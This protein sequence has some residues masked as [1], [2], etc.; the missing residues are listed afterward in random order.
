MTQTAITIRPAEIGDAR[1][2]ESVHD[3]AW[4][5]AY[6][7]IIPGVELERMVAR[8]GASWWRSAIRRGARIN[9]LDHQDRIAG[10]ASYGRNRSP[11][12]TQEA[13]IYELYLAPEFQGFGLGVRLFRAT[14]VNARSA[15]LKGVAVWA[16][17]GNE[18][19]LV[20]YTRLGGKVLKRSTGRFGKSIYESTAFGWD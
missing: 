8:R 13:E 5:E 15:G 19:A 9:V 1:G 6:R 10:Y 4:R 17:S 7:G 2:I 11:W 14:Q 16:L 3:A 18:R 20:F 12:L